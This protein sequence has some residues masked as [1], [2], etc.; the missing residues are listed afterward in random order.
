MLPTNE[1]YQSDQSHSSSD[2]ESIT[3]LLKEYNPSHNIYENK[4]I[5]TDD[6]ENIITNENK[7]EN[8]KI[9]KEKSTDELLDKIFEEDIESDIHTINKNT[10]K[11]DNILQP[12]NNNK[13]IIIEEEKYPNN[14][15]NDN[16]IKKTKTVISINSLISSNSSTDKGIVCIFIF[17]FFYFIIYF[18]L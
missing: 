15:N 6:K 16:N 11:N 7:Q 2:N 4:E 9:V 13:R 3:S 12:I 8:D 10:K 17:Y 5:K 14:E 1:T 18:C